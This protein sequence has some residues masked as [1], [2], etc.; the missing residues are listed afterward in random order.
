MSLKS[1]LIRAV[2]GHLAWHRLPVGNY[3]MRSANYARPRPPAA[4]ALAYQLYREA[5]RASELSCRV[6]QGVGDVGLFDQ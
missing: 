3:A 1:I 5:T 4:L 2:S 6:W